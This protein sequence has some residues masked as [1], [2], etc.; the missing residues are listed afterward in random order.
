MQ[1][2]YAFFSKEPEVS[3]GR[4]ELLRSI[5]NTHAL[6][7]QLLRLI[8]ELKSLEEN[9]VEIAKNKYIQGAEDQNPN[10]R[11]IDNPAIKKMEQ[12][13]ALNSKSVGGGIWLWEEEEEIL[14]QLYSEFSQSE[15]Y[16]NYMNKDTDSFSSGRKFVQRFYSRF[17][18]E[19]EIFEQFLEEKSIYLNDDLWVVLGII[20]LTL[21]KLKADT[22]ELPL[23]PLYA[24][25]EDSKF[26]QQLLIKTINNREYAKELIEG[27]VPN[28]EYERIAL[29]DRLIMLMAIT[30]LT[31][32]SEIPVKVSL[33]EYLEIAKFYSTEDSTTFINGVLDKVVKQLEKENK[34]K[35]TGKGLLGGI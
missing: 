15:L 24:N 11:F 5:E 25:E 10:M 18:A 34:I 20:E 13:K 3:A 30:E 19:S 22:E 31:E 17:L 12:S 26:A 23:L 33:N 35:K 2:T 8:I 7:V 14:R 6:Y 27:A 4:K 9:K 16:E 32:F 29:M 1:I 28:W 21:R